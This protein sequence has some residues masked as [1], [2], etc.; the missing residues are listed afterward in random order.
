MIQ[1][2]RSLVSPSNPAQNT[3]ACQRAMR[4]SGLLKQLCDILMASGIPADILTETINAVAEVIRGCADNQELFAGVMAPSTPPRPAIVVLLMSM[5]NEKQP[6]ILR[7][8]VLYCFQCYLFKNELG[9]KQV[10][11]GHIIRKLLTVRRNNPI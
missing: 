8:A 3:A 6:F 1:L 9:Q 11:E 5:V 4:L 10:G 2:V 7:C